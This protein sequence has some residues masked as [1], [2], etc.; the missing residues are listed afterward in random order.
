MIIKRNL[1]LLMGCSVIPIA[2]IQQNVHAAGLV[3]EEVTVTARKREE[4][5]TDVP[6]SITAITGDQISTSGL[7]NLEDMAPGIPNFSFSEAVSGNDQVFVRGLGS[8][9]NSGFENAVGQVLN[10]FFFG[11]SRFGRAAFLDLQQIEVLKGPQ[12]ALIGKNTTAGAVNIRTAMPTE[13][14]EGYLTA[15][16]EF[17]ADEGYTLEGA[18]SGALSD[19]VR[20]RL[21]FKTDDRDGWM[22]NLSNGTNPVEREDYTV[23]GLLDIDLTDTLTANL[24][25]QF[26]DSERVG[27]NREYAICSP[28]AQAALAGTP[29]DCRLNYTTASNRVESGV[30][31]EELT[32]TEFSMG[33][34]TLNWDLENITV[35]SLTGF[36]E[37]ETNDIWDG[38]QTPLDITITGID[39]DFEQWSQEL[40][41]A[42]NGDGALSYIAGVYFLHTEQETHF[43][44]DLLGPGRLRVINTQQESDTISLFGQATW[45]FSEAWDIT[46]GLRYTKEEKEADQQQ[47]LAVSLSD[48]VPVAVIP[49]GGPF[50]N[51]HDI[52]ADREENNV[53][54]NAVLRW[55][56]NDDSM[57]Y[58][59]FSQGF[60]GGGFDHLMDRPQAT[61]LADFEFEEEEVT[62]Y[63]LGGKLSLADGA[64]QLNFALF[65]SE[66]DDLQVSSLIPGDTVFK[67]GNAASAITQGL[68]A[69]LT[70]L[71]TENFKL[72]IAAAYLDAE[73]D[74]FVNGPCYALQTTGCITTPGGNVQDLS[75]E[76]LQYAP[77]TS[78]TI[79]G[80]YTWVLGKYD[81]SLF[82][83][84][85]HSASFQSATD[86][87]PNTIQKSYTKYDAT[88]SLSPQDEQWNIALVGRNLS[89]KL[90]TNFAN[91]AGPSSFIGSYFYFVESPFALSL[92]AT[93]KF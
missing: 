54:P 3:L 20:G 31:Q 6:I 26:G 76:N 46:A 24:M 43:T 2:G 65:R 22:K 79:N 86:N 93:M 25:Y 92:Q 80:E 74:D 89:D 88:L 37:Y 13:E 45:E 17:E 64:A 87:D 48:S 77:E 27:R 83:Q 39:E 57:Y 71:V 40:R 12:G 62:A 5:L 55:R 59:S 70:W 8:G 29:E 68:E 81:L 56:P 15:T 28:T 34:I 73:Y 75:G 32:D 49:G 85:Y 30:Q 35:T 67:V 19:S 9:V 82:V 53:S 66:F 91:D 51:H 69:D 10:G 90:T 52:E 1:L 44:V 38:D 63:E 72:F 14:L 33:G 41:V 21:A 47:F 50:T 7:A 60:K 4:T 23:R 61:A 78:F 11:R 16:Y 58:L 36:S 84:A 42:S 18:V